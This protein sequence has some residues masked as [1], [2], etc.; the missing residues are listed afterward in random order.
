M[1]L[2][3]RSLDHIKDNLMNLCLRLEVVNENQFVADV[4]LSPQLVQNAYLLDIYPLIHGVINNQE[5]T[6]ISISKI[7]LTK[8]QVDNFS[9]FIVADRDI[10]ASKR[11][12]KLADEITVCLSEVASGIEAIVYRNSE[13]ILTEYYD[14]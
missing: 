12:T 3:L 1:I 6:A 10:R 2:P 11:A 9:D 7:F 14:L 4:Y 5:Y 13:P 8:D